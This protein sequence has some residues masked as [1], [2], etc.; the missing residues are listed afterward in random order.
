MK[1][2]KYQSIIL[3]LLIALTTSAVGVLFNSAIGTVEPVLSAGTSTANITVGLKGYW[4]Q[5]FSTGSWS[6]LRGRTPADGTG[7]T[8]GN[9]S[10]GW[11]YP[12]DGY[13]NMKYVRIYRSGL[14]FNVTAFQG[15]AITNPVLHVK[16]Y[17]EQ[18][19]DSPPG[20][21]WGFWPNIYTGTVTHHEFDTAE[22]NASYLAPG[23]T[24][25]SAGSSI[26]SSDWEAGEWYEYPLNFGDVDGWF[27]EPDDAGFVWCVLGFG[28]DYWNNAPGFYPNCN[29]DVIG[30]GI[31]Y[32]GNSPYL[33]FNYAT[34]AV[35]R[36]VIIDDN[37]PVN[38]MP[39]G[40]EV[41]DNITWGSPRCAFADEDLWFK[42]N[43]ES[44]ANI[45]LQLLSDT[46]LLL[47][48][49]TDSIRTDGVYN[50]AIPHETFSPDTSSWVRAYELNSRI[51][52]TWGRVEPE[53]SDSMELLK[54]YAVDTEY[55]Q[56]D[57]DFNQY[58]VYKN[59]LMYIYWK[60][61]LAIGDMTSY[62]FRIWPGGDGDN[63][64]WQNAMSWINENVYQCDS[65]NY[66]LAHWRYL[67]FTP[68]ETLSGFNNRDGLVQNLDIDYLSENTGFLE[69]V[70]TDNLGVSITLTHSCHYYLM[71]ESEGVTVSVS[72]PSYDAGETMTV[73]VTAG[74]KSKI[75]TKLDSVLIW[76]INDG[77]ALVATGNGDI[78]S[79]SA[80]IDIVLPQ[81]EGDYQVRAIFYNDEI[82]PYYRYIHDIPFGIG[83]GNTGDDDEDGGGGQS[84]IDNIGGWLGRLGLN[85]AGGHWLA[86][87][88]GMLALFMLCYKSQVMRV[89]FPLCLFAAAIIFGWIDIWFVILLAF[90]AGVFIFSM[91]RK[92]TTGQGE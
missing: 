89:V 86:L 24:L 69:S 87:I 84:I 70:I 4:W 90:G 61:N 12:F 88:L 14:S 57:Y 62:Y 77:G 50:W 49:V 56:Y 10:V 74:Q 34:P 60:T 32:T 54:T 7:S 19:D 53:P 15:M 13:E 80:D 91:L 83:A 52:S 41:A 28:S 63:P 27:N 44:G 2:I 68:M 17:T 66:Y 30:I 45:T 76:I 82:T 78:S 23:N 6:Y 21:G 36:V 39:D 22:L 79:G 16:C 8:N 81:I 43:G 11:Q 37:D 58:I 72:K 3:V 47:D 40:D 1:R 33:T 5:E 20:A 38:P 48:T 65:E 18:H 59:D 9:I 73:T 92:K 29:D 25:L 51:Y 67:I 71:D 64:A 55:P 46:G 85:N 35:A 31:Y 75:P 42:C 26:K